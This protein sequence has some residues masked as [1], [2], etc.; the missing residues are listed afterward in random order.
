MG[1]FARRVVAIVPGGYRAGLAVILVSLGAPALSG[2]AHR[3]TPQDAFAAAGVRSAADIS[4]E[5]GVTGRPIP[6]GFLGLSIEYWAVEAYAGKDPSAINPTLVQLVR[7]LAAGHAT[8]MRIG[9]V[10][11]D[12]TWWPVARHRR[13]PGVNY[14]LSERRLA[15]IR[16]VA[17]AVDARLT[18]GIN[19]EAD[20]TA[21]AAAEARA[22]LARIGRRRIAAFELGNEPELYGNAAFG[23]Y[24]RDGQAV[25]GR[26][27]TYDMQA[28]TDDFSR[29]GFGLPLAPLAGPASGGMRW[30]GQL[31]DF[32]SAE[33]RLRLVTVHR[34]PMQACYNTPGSPSYPTV[35]RLL[36]PAASRSLAYG[37]ARYLAVAHRRHLR[38]R[39]DEMNTISCGDPPSVRDTFAMALWVLDAL[40]ADAQVGVDGVNIHTYPSAPYQLFK[41][42]HTNSH[43]DAF[44]E[45]EYYGLLLFSQAAPPGARLLRTSGGSDAVR[46]WATRRAGTTR[47][48]LINDDTTRSHLA[49]VRVSGAR[50]TATL[51]RLLAPSAHATT[52]VTL[53]GQGYGAATDTGLMPGRPGTSVLAAAAGKYLVRL[54]AA[55]AAMLTLR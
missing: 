33:P 46:V 43:W 20:S 22:I 14:S 24:L 54:P 35:G 50:G 30:L 15:V 32:A 55:S 29:I 28:F 6:L 25:T 51:E 9:G 1:S 10:S 31:A 11:T 8:E 4:V 44:V 16:A 5:R 38:F 37:V 23:W 40:F 17:D 7:N 19:L 13:P 39:I 12:K 49:A 48:V 47:V 41:F 27:P 34:Y 52:Q 36:S 18:M 26:P 53:A 42:Q 45:P 2:A 3:T 21:L